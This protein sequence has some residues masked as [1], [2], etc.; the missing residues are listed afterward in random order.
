MFLH[1]V[2]EGLDLREFENAYSDEG[3]E[4]Y[5]ASLMLKVW[6][7]AYALGMTSRGG[8]SSVSG[9]IWGCA[10]CRVGSGRITGRWARC[11]GGKGRALNDVFTQVVEIARE[12]GRLGTVALDSTRI[13][14]CASRD[15][16]DTEQ[17]LRNERAKIRRW[18]KCGGGRRSGGRRGSAGGGG[19]SGTAAGGH[20]ATLRAA[21]QERPGQAVAAGWGGA[22]SAGAR[23]L[24]A[25]LHGG[26][27]GE[28]RSSD[29][30]PAGHAQSLRCAGAGAVGKG[31][32]GAHGSVS[33]KSL[34]RCRILQQPE[35]AG[36]R[37]AWHR[38]VCA[39]PEPGAGAEH[40]QA[41]CVRLGATGC[42]V[43]N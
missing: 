19:E 15:G 29:C 3:G 8:W 21:A 38:R 36:V 1:R 11:G 26:D 27:C 41:G 20:P 6:L 23:R 18:K 31:G 14:A 35:C 17:R 25:G 12:L 9:R 32:G 37:S 10:I 5:A 2:V 40:G 43:R 16:I 22:L 34:G 4:L 24:R 33:G 42:A 28:P 7:Y 30:N 13:R 39:R